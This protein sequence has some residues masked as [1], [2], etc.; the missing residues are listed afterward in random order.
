MNTFVREL[1]FFIFF[2]L[3]Y[4]PFFYFVMFVIQEEPKF[5]YFFQGM[6]VAFIVTYVVK[7]IFIIMKNIK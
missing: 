5:A 4:F 3:G 2:V 1:K 7:F 6:I